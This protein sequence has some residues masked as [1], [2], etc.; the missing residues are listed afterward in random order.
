MEINLNSINSGVKWT[1]GS[2]VSLQAT[3]VGGKR[4]QSM[5]EGKNIQSTKAFDPMAAA[6]PT[7]EVPEAALTRD[8][9]LGNLVSSAFNL[10]P[11]P[12][13]NFSVS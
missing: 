5:T 10:A 12:M 4:L 1:E 3:E 13:P 11:P 8:D 9:D 6:E 7:A 2:D